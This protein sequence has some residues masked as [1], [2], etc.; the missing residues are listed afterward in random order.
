MKAYYKL[1]VEVGVYTRYDGLIRTGF[2]ISLSNVPVRMFH[3]SMVLTSLYATTTN[4]L[5]T[6]E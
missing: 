5:K 6:I 3:N 1:K 2:V 4:R